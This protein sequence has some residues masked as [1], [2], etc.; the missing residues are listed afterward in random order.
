LFQ[1]AQHGM[2]Y[3]NPMSKEKNK[4]GVDQKEKQFGLKLMSEKAKD[5]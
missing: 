2:P 3:A 4:K 1:D 5:F